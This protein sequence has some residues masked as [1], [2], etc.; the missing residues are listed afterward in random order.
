MEHVSLSVFDY[1]KK[2][3]CDLY[4]SN[5]FTTGQAYNIV[6]TEEIKMGWKELSFD[7]PF[8]TEKGRNIRWSFIK[9][10]Y[11]LR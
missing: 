1:N 9:N 7:L 8:M 4:D 2:K 6:L 10:D 5:L 3:I 11:L